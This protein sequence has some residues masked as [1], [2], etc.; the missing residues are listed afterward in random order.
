[1]HAPPVLRPA[2]SSSW[3]R[4]AR[5]APVPPTTPADALAFATGGLLR[6]WVDQRGCAYVPSCWAPDSGHVCARTLLTSLPSSLSRRALVEY[7][8]VRPPLHLDAA[9][10]RKPYVDP[11]S[12]DGR[13]F[14]SSDFGPM[15]LLLACARRLQQD[16]QP[17][18]LAGSAALCQ[19]PDQLGLRLARLPQ[20]CAL[21][22]PVDNSRS[23]SQ[24]RA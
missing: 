7:V 20:T 5:V 8:Q 11:D 6:S 13:R 10:W 14:Q 12:K 1:M 16:V 2:T 3:R 21:C 19:H 15:V 17:L 22:L 24:R 23:R 4:F 9:R 18:R